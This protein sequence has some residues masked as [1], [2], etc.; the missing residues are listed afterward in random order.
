MLALSSSR[1]IHHGGRA[2]DL[3]AGSALLKRVG[4]AEVSGCLPSAPILIL[5]ARMAGP[6]GYAVVILNE[7][8]WPGEVRHRR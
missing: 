7:K 6:R 5:G 8:S 4:F 1:R 3:G 2:G